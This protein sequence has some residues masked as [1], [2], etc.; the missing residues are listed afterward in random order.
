MRVYICAPPYTNVCRYISEDRWCRMPGHIFSW[1]STSSRAQVKPKVLCVYI[2]MYIVEH[3][4]HRAAI[5]T[6]PAAISKFFSFHL[7]VD[8]FFILFFYFV[9][10]IMYSSVDFS[11]LLSTSFFFVFSL[12]FWPSTRARVRLRSLSSHLSNASTARWIQILPSWLFFIFLN[13]KS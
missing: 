1:C 7:F 10:Y 13:R 9:F 5:V 11:H 8:F 2:Y 3:Q 6:S 4:Q 12:L